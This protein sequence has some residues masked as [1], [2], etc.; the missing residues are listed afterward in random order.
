MPLGRLS[1]AIDRLID[2]GQGLDARGDP[3]APPLEPAEAERL[4]AT[5]RAARFAEAA[6]PFAAP[7]AL[8]GTSS[9]V[10][11]W[12]RPPA[13][14]SAWCILSLPYGGF[15]RPDDLGLY[16]LHARAL[17]AKGFGVAAPEMPYHGARAMPGRRS[18]WGFVR[19]DLGHT[20]RAC[21]AA[22][23][24]VSALA[25][26]LREVRGAQRVVG[27]GISLGGNALGLAAA[28]GAPVER[29][30]F[31]AAVDN[32]VSFYRTGENREARRRTLA[33]AGVTL[34]DVG[35]AF[36]PVSPST[37]PPPA[38]ALFAVPRH[39][40]VVPA[41]T[42]EAWRAAWRG[43]R[44]DLRWEGHGVALASPL[45]ARRIAAWLARGVR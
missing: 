25:R 45:A 41:S 43:E 6:P 11:A 22:A 5:V 39:D 8:D 23:A 33:A 38:P 28:M 10:G 21:A 14:G 37:Y 34:D 15:A 12:L 7:V 40:L 1:R 16:N 44:L 9:A 35:R 18:G 27:L 4:L 29:L 19:A 31:L 24:D 26:H 42:Q 2:R 3:Y 17:L 30:A 20:T 32:P 13:R 36:E